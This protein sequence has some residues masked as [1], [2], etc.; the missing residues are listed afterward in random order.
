MT[1]KVFACV[2]LALAVAIVTW[3]ALT[4]GVFVASKFLVVMAAF[5]VSHAAGG[6]IA[7]WRKRRAAKR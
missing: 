7:S 3:V 1:V 5:A 2:L 4:E 6:E